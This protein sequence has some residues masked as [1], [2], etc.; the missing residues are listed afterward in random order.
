MRVRNVRTRKK[1]RTRKIIILAS[2]HAATIS[3]DSSLEQR[4]KQDQND[5][6]NTFVY[7]LPYSSMLRPQKGTAVIF[8]IFFTILPKLHF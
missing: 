1:L 6:D 4:K 5:D 8:A 7:L 2:L 3:L